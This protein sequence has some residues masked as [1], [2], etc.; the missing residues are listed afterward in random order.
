MSPREIRL[1]LPWRGAELELDLFTEDE[2]ER[3]VP[4]GVDPRLDAARDDSRAP[5]PGA[6]TLSFP[7]PRGRG[8]R[9]NCL[10][11]RVRYTLTSI[12]VVM[13]ATTASNICGARSR[14]SLDTRSV[15]C[16]FR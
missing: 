13:L 9:G 10:A 12:S 15:P 1:G 16:A 8:G 2:V 3:D 4:P 5:G 11:S 6:P 14:N 7:A